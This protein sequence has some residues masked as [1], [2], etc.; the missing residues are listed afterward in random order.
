MYDFKKTSN[1]KK[2]RIEKNILQKQIAKDLGMKQSSYSLIENNIY[3]INVKTLLKI[4]NYLDVST[5]YLLGLKE[6]EEEN[7]I[8]NENRK[9]VNLK[10]TTDDKAILNLDEDDKKEWEKAIE[11]LVL[12]AIDKYE[13]KKKISN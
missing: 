7:K 2:I 8:E 12:K 3:N 13:K 1:L 11:N 10:I 6:I 9:I 5:D 4:A